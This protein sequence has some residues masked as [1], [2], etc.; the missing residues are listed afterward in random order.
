M[1]KTLALVMCSEISVPD[2]KISVSNGGISDVNEM[3]SDVH[4]AKSGS[5]L[6]GDFV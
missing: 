1:V 5:I 3:S 2:S 4:S 6:N